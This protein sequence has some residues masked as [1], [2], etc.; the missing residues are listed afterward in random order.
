MESI[1]MKQHQH[2]TGTQ[3][4]KSGVFQGRGNRVDLL[5]V[6]VDGPELEVVRGVDDA[7][8]KVVDEFVVERTS[9]SGVKEEL[10]SF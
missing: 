2:F 6:H 1:E 7:H 8:W 4:H 10:R 9:D 3:S 5:K